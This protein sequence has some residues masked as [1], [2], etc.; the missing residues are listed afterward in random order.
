MPRRGSSRRRWQNPNHEIYA[1]V[2]SGRIHRAQGDLNAAEIALAQAEAV[3]TPRAVVPILPAMVD[4]LSISLRL[5]RGDLTTARQWADAQD[6]SLEAPVNIDEMLRA[7]TV[8]QVRV[9]DGDPAGALALLNPI[10]AEAEAQGR[11]DLAIKARIRQ[12]LALRAQGRRDNAVDALRAALALGAPEGY[13]RPFLD[14]GSAL[15]GLLAWIDGP[16]QAYAAQILRMMGAPAP[17]VPE[18]HPGLIE[19]LTD[20][21]REVLALMAEGRTNPEIADALVIA[22]G[23]VKAHTARIYG[24]LDVHNRTEAAA[25]AHEL[26]LL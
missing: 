24:K 20:R 16:N 14:A 1:Q 13:V 19:P 2:V 12:A 3:G 15:A 11:G 22:T 23:T 21:E 7:L 4:R 5:D 8:A 6:L 17:E 18:L 26:G 9:A 25:R 10:V